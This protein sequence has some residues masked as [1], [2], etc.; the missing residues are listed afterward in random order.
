VNR[1][2]KYY[3]D[4]SQYMISHIDYDALGCERSRFDRILLSLTSRFETVEKLR[5]AEEII[6]EKIDAFNDRYTMEIADA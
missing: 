2:G 5:E 4:G 1:F 6:R 3:F